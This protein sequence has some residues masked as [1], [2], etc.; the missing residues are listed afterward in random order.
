MRSSC[1][2]SAS[3]TIQ[4]RSRRI[5]SEP[6]WQLCTVLP[7]L[8]NSIM[9]NVTVAPGSSLSPAGVRCPAERVMAHACST[10]RAS[11]AASKTKSAPRPWLMPP[12]SPERSMTASTGSTSVGSRAVVAPRRRA[13]SRRWGSGSIAMIC[14]ARASRAACT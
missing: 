14:A 9:G 4:G 6:C 5:R 11:R 2:C 12:R 1:P 7:W 10:A 13:A 8:E 3:R